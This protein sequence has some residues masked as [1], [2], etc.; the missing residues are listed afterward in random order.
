MTHKLKSCPSELYTCSW[1]GPRRHR[2]G[3]PAGGL[4]TKR[5]TAKVFSLHLITFS[6]GAST[7]SLECGWLRVWRNR[8][9]RRGSNCEDPRNVSFGGNGGFPAL[10]S[11][12]YVPDLWHIGGYGQPVEQ[13]NIKQQPR[14]YQSSHLSL[15]LHRLFSRNHFFSLPTLCSECFKLKQPSNIRGLFKKYAECLNCA[16]RVGFGRIRSMS[17]G[18]YGSAD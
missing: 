7:G 9:T 1:L 17:L 2:G 18:S 10:S 14:I 5:R 12:N 4:G 16:A 15:F 3:H 6:D 13:T 11:V 8:R